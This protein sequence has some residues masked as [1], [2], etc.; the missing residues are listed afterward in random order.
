MKTRKAKLSDLD[1][2][3]NL[4]VKFLNHNIQFG[5]F[6]YKNKPKINKK[7]L[8]HSLK[9][10]IINSKKNIFLVAEENGKLDGFVQAEIMS[11][12]ESR[13][14]KK[15]VEIV[16]IYSELKKKGTGK[17]LLKE[18]EKWARLNNAKFILWEFIYGN[19]SAENFCVK[20]KFKYFKVKMLKKLRWQH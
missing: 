11:N 1:S 19:K 5:K 18:I 4:Y 9:K 7:E 8:K 12:R 6:I 16:D 15:V 13:T 14:A 2:I 20:N 10:R 17:K 3:T